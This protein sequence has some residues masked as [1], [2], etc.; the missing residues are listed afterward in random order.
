LSQSRLKEAST[1]I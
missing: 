1:Q